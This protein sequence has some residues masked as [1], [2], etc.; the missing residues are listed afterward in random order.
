MHDSARGL[1][2]Y[3]DLD[4]LSKKD[5]KIVLSF[6]GGTLRGLF[7]AIAKAAILRL[8]YSDDFPANENVTLVSEKTLKQTL[9]D[10]A[11]KHSLTYE[12]YDSD[13]FLVRGPSTRR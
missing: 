7:D 12:V 3:G 11:V 9:T 4:T 10:L 1:K 6:K 13:A 5:A 2:D 8:D